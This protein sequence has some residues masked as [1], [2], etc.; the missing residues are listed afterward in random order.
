MR[1]DERV[2]IGEEEP[3]DRS[4]DTARI[5][6]RTPFPTVLMHRP[7][8]Y[9]T[10]ITVLALALG[11]ILLGDKSFWLDEGYSFAYAQS[12]WS[13][14]WKVI[15]TSQANMS[16]YYVLLH[17]WLGIGTGE[18]AIRALSV[19]FVAGTIPLLY[20][21]GRRLL[22][23]LPALLACLLFAVNSFAI[24]YAQEA[25]GYSL[26]VFLSVLSTLL[27]VR[28]IDR[29]SFGRWAA[30]AFVGGVA[31][32]AH[33]F[34][35]FVLAAHLAALLFLGSRRP[36]V[37]HLI[38][39]YAA[40]AALVS[41]LVLFVFTRSKGQISWIPRPTPTSLIRAFEDLSGGLGP[42]LPLAYFVVGTAGA[43]AAWRALR[44]GRLQPWH[45]VLVAAW[46]LIP[47]LGSFVLSFAKPI[48]ISKYLI[49]AL[50]ALALGVGFGLATLPSKG[51]V[52]GAT[53]VVVAL[54]AVGLT[55]W[56]S[57]YEKDDWRGAARF[58]V[59]GARPG[60]GIVVVPTRVRKALEYYVVERLGKA[61]D[62]PEPIYPPQE[63]GRYSTQAP[64]GPNFEDYL[65]AQTSGYARVWL[66]LSKGSPELRHSAARAL[67]ADFALA[68]RRDFTHVKVRLYEGGRGP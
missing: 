21:L 43:V 13:G 56:Y 61:G 48:F 62:A 39:V 50:P 55:R 1:Q 14:L 18:F 40:V 68:A 41:P 63:W 27:F 16:L 47:V 36:R 32:Y 58:L 65:R 8:V 15:S 23:D 7:T 2:D 57:G 59:D 37:R 45:A 66:V 31:A 35:A 64:K 53:V 49:V 25:R 10:A 5:E 19:L 54:S 30:Y 38:A 33:F 60:D 9:V 17:P 26:A 44:A 46:F 42:W 3:L 4:T 67:S 51:A 11:F 20:A 6:A 29:P 24:R 52:V 22:G 34:M 12:D 28:A